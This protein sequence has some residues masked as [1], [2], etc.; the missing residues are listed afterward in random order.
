MAWTRVKTVHAGATSAIDTS[1]LE[2]GTFYL[3]KVVAYYQAIDCYSSPAR[4]KYNEFEYFLRVYWS[5]DGLTESLE[6]GVE[7][8]PNPGGNQLNIS[9]TMANATLQVFNLQGRKMLE[10][11]VTE[12]TV[13]IEWPSGMY[14]WMV[15]ASGV[16]PSPYQWASSETLVETGKWIKE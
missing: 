10:T 12:G 8:Y 16:N 9:T 15:Y 7:V 4:S 11:I 5:V 2:D 14:F 1:P 6:K 3:Y 13:T